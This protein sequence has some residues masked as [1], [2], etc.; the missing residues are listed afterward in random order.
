MTGKVLFTLLAAGFCLGCVDQYGRVGPPDPIGQA[1]F[2]ALDPATPVYRPQEYAVETD[3]PALRDERRRT[4][5]PV[6]YSDPVWVKGYWAWAGNDWVWVPGRWVQRPRQN[7][8]W[9]DGRYYTTSDRRYWRSGYWQE[10]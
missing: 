8:V 9:S 3:I 6:G 4:V 10:M 2:N 1:I 7:V 5:V